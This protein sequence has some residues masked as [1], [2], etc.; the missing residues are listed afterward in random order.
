MRRPRRTRIRSFGHD[1]AHASSGKVDLG[2]LCYTGTRKNDKRE[3]GAMAGHQE[4]ER[5]GD[6]LRIDESER[7]SWAS[8]AFIRAGGM[9]SAPTLM[10]G[11]ALGFGPGF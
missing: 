11:A 6:N 1:C 4:A 8:I 2:L 5:G 3:S 7:K 9:F 10:V